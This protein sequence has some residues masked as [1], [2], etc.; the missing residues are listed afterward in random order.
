MQALFQKLLKLP[1]AEW[2]QIQK[3]ALVDLCLLG[4]YSDDRISLAEQ[5]FIE[6]ESTQLKWESGISFSG[7]L[8]RTI[9]K[10][11]GVRNNSQKTKELLRD[12]ADR[13]KDQH[14]KQKAVEELEKLLFIDGVVQLEEEFLGEV[15]AAMGI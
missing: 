10:V 4:M 6:D 3:E 2:N 13:L 11:R 7:Y 8:Q 12:I 5:D 14:L 9:P 1:S 15:K